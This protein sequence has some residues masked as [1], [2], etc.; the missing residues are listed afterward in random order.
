MAHDREPGAELTEAFLTDVAGR[1]FDERRR[2]EVMIETFE[3]A[4]ERLEAEADA[5]RAAAAVLETVMLGPEGMADLMARLGVPAALFAAASSRASRPG[6]L[7]KPSGL[8]RRRRYLAA[9]IGAYD[10]LFE[11]VLRYRNGPVPD[12]ADASAQTQVYYNLVREMARMVN[13]RVEEVNASISPSCML[14]YVK[15]FNPRQVAAETVTG[16][17]ACGL[18]SSLNDRLCYR[19]VHLDDA[20]VPAFPLLPPPSRVARKLTAAA[21]RI[22]RDRPL[23]VRRLLE[24]LRRQ[25]SRG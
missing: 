25:S 20:R 17:G 7:P 8:G 18:E 2:L 3:A 15:Q 1:Y 6:G 23:E 5:V 14:N 13:R 19:P 22:H 11:A 24:D 4:L 21:D 16:G 12:T 10:G 9:V